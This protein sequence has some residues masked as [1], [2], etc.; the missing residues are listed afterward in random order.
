MSKEFFIGLSFGA[1]GLMGMASC[2]LSKLKN[3]SKDNYE[4]KIKES[5]K[6]NK[7]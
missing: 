7:I 4:M 2:Y 3:Q 1:I 5:L 6:V